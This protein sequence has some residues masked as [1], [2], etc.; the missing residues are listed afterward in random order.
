MAYGYIQTFLQFPNAKNGSLYIYVANSTEPANVYDPV[1]ANIISQPLSIDSD[2]YCQQFWVDTDNL[3]DMDVRTFNNQQV[4]THN[5]VSVLGGSAG[6]T[7]PQGPQ[8]VQGVKGD[9]GPAGANG[10]DGV[11]GTN[12]VDGAD[13]ADGVSLVSI[14][15]DQESDYGRI[16]YNKSDN[17]NTWYEAGNIVPDGVGKVKVSASDAAGFLENKVVAG[18]N[19]SVVSNS[20]KLTIN[21]TAPETFKTQASQYSTV[22]DFL[23]MIIE[24]T[25]CLTVSTS[26]DFNKI[27]FCG[28]GIGGSGITPRGEW[29]VAVTYDEGDGVWYYDDTVS[30]IIN[31]YY[32]ATATTTGVNPFTVGTGWVIMFS[33]DQLGD[34]MVKLDSADSTTSFLL[35]KIKAGDGIVFTRTVDAAGDYITVSGQQVFTVT[36]TNASRTI[37]EL[38]HDI[39]FREGVWTRPLYVGNEI[40]IDHLNVI[41]SALKTSV[42]YTATGLPKFD[43]YGHFK[44]ECDPIRISDVSGLA[45][46][47]TA[48]GDGKV[49]ID[50]A[51]TKDYLINKLSAGT[52]ITITD[53]GSTLEISSDLAESSSF[54]FKSNYNNAGNSGYVAIDQVVFGSQFIDAPNHKIQNLPLG[55]LLLS[56]NLKA[57]SNF[58]AFDYSED[59]YSGSTGT[60]T[61]IGGENNPLVKFSST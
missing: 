45:E 17:V 27:I 16:I 30:P 11:D 40:A 42:M 33:I 8:G 10:V 22:K 7:G 13:G 1:N 47:I 49:K 31:R 48:A 5:N 38:S 29:D 41:E 46:A 15:V 3:Y 50:A 14:L 58:G 6:A 54:F 24:G 28:A 4:E 56:T 51:D 34:Q 43:D 19:I 12:G 9:T 21:N 20:Q 26:A 39:K 60:Q 35:D 37:D 32:V 44:N 18:T 55:K 25:S 23:N 59:C 2:G 52:G 61:Y 57:T 36:T 53:A